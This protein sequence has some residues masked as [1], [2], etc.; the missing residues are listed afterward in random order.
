MKASD[1]SQD[2]FAIAAQ[3]DIHTSPHGRCGWRESNSSLDACR[4]W[5]LND[6][7]RR[8]GRVFAFD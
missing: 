7:Q 1:S 8:R 4:R 3:T 6:R 5:S 2:A